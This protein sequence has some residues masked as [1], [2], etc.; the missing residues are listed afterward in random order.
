M[1]YTILMT[2]LNDLCLPVCLYDCLSLSVSVCLS[3]SVSIFLSGAIS[4]FSHDGRT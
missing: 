2:I 4:L 3:V 1:I